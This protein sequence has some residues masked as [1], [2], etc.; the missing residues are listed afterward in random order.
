MNKVFYKTILFDLFKGYLLKYLD[1][2]ATLL[3]TSPLCT[4]SC[5]AK[6]DVYV[7]QRKISESDINKKRRQT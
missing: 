2:L 5:F 4:V 6:T 7:P 3:A 1:G